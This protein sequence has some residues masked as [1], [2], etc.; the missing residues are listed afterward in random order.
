M[1]AAIREY[2]HALALE[3][4]PEIRANLALALVEEDAPQA[5]ARA[6]PAAR[7]EDRVAHHAPGPDRGVVADD[8]PPQDGARDDGEVAQFADARFRP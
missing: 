1:N 3:P 6:D 2:R 4:R 5:G 7:E 8:A